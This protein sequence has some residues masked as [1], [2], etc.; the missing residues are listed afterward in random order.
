MAVE[1]DL[2]LVTGELGVTLS[3]PFELAIV[4]DDAT[5]NPAQLIAID[6]AH[7]PHRS[8]LTDG[9]RA[10]ARNAQVRRGADELGMRVADRFS[11]DPILSV[12]SEKRAASERIVDNLGHR[13][14][15]GCWC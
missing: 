4:A 14:S 3:K 6:I 13:V 8:F 7:R 15:L 11:T 5:I 1:A 2:D 9:T 12:V 10:V